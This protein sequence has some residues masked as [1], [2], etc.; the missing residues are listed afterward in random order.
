MTAA[1]ME[2][3]NGLAKTQADI[4]VIKGQIKAGRTGK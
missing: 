4:D 2:V 1:L 3:L